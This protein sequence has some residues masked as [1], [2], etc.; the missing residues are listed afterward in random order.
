MIL[1]HFQ[2]PSTRQLLATAARLGADI[3]GS[4]FEA[5]T[6]LGFNLWIEAA[7][8]EHQLTLHCVEFDSLSSDEV[9][10]RNLYLRRSALPGF[11]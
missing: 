5:I 4:A 8:Q 3:T 6:V 1:Q 9:S 2:T 7:D 11:S 10:L